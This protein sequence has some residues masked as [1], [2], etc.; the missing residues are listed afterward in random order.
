MKAFGYFEEEEFIIIYRCLP[1]NNKERL[2]RL[3]DLLKE[4]GKTLYVLSAGPFINPQR[5]L[6]DTGYDITAFRSQRKTAKHWSYIERQA[7]DPKIKNKTFPVLKMGHGVMVDYE[8]A[9]KNGCLP[10]IEDSFFIH[11]QF[12]SMS[13]EPPILGNKCELCRK[14][15]FKKF[16]VCPRCGICLRCYKLNQTKNCWYCKNSVPQA[17]ETKTRVIQI[18]AKETSPGVYFVR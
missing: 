6:K 13:Q 17:L 1:L 10:W 15:T 3:I 18:E 12:K 9:Q 8:L 11:K 2:L 7:A 4:R 5:M 16:A 14:V